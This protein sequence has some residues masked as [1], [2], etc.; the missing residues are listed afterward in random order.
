LINRGKLL[1]LVE[2]EKNEELKDRL[3]RNWTLTLSVLA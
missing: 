2:A 3:T 1:R